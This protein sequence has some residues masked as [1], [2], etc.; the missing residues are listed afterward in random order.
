MDGKSTGTENRGLHSGKTIDGE[1]KIGDQLCQDSLGGLYE[2]TNAEKDDLIIKLFSG[3]I[4][5]TAT[6]E[7]YPL[8]PN[9]LLPVAV[10]APGKL[11]RYAVVE[12]FVKTT[13]RDWM[14]IRLHSTAENLIAT[15]LQLTSA[16]HAIHE[17]GRALGNLCPEIVLI[18]E[19]FMGKLEVYLLDANIQFSARAMTQRLYQPLEQL[20]APKPTVAGDIWSVGAMMYEALYKH[21]PYSGKTKDELIA[22]IDKETLKF[23]TFARVPS[24]FIRIIQK[25]LAKD[26]Q[27]RYASMQELG[28]DL[29]LLQER[30]V[31]KNVSSEA[32]QKAIHDSII[33]AARISVAPSPKEK[34]ARF[35]LAS[36]SAGHLSQTRISEVPP[37]KVASRRS[38]ASASS[39]RTSKAPQKSPSSATRSMLTWE[40]SIIPKTEPQASDK[41]EDATGKKVDVRPKTD[42]QKTS[43]DKPR[44]SKI[45]KRKATIAFAKDPFGTEEPSTALLNDPWQQARNEAIQKKKPEKKTTQASGTAPK[46]E[47]TTAKKEPQTVSAQITETR[48]SLDDKPQ[49]DIPIKSIQKKTQKKT[50]ATAGKQNGLLEK[51]SSPDAKGQPEKDK[52]AIAPEEKKPTQKKSTVL[53][54]QAVAPIDITPKADKAGQKNRERTGT[55]QAKRPTLKKP[56]ASLKDEKPQVDIAAPTQQTAG[57]DTSALETPTEQAKRPRSGRPR[58]QTML[59]MPAIQ[60]PTPDVVSDKMVTTDASGSRPDTGALEIPDSD[61]TDDMEEEKTLPVSPQALTDAMRA[62]AQ[63]L[64]NR[65]DNT[66]NSDISSPASHSNRDALGDKLFDDISMADFRLPVDPTMQPRLPGTFRDEAPVDSHRP[67]PVVSPPA[68]GGE[69]METSAPNIPRPRA[70]IQLKMAAMARRMAQ[71]FALVAIFVGRTGKTA[72]TRVATLWKGKIASGHI[73]KKISVGVT[74]SWHRFN[75]LERKKKI[76]A[77]SVLAMVLLLSAIGIALGI[78]A[79]GDNRSQSDLEKSVAGGSESLSDPKLFDGEQQSGGDV[80]Q[81]TGDSVEKKSTRD[82]KK[83]RRMKKA[84]K[85]RKKAR[86]QSIISK[87]ESHETGTSGASARDEKKRA[88]RKYKRRASLRK[89]EVSGEDISDP[90]YNAGI[91]RGTNA[92]D[93]EAPPKKPETTAKKAAPKKETETQGKTIDNKAP[94]KTKP[95]VKKASKTEKPKAG[96]KSNTGAPKKKSKEKKPKSGDWATNPF[97]G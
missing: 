31:D 78:S 73:R 6:K 96:Q 5:I 10:S 42:T 43:E 85:R 86:R 77:L 20:K 29:L 44:K 58:S 57:I 56:A 24:A 76:I 36:L 2:C 66:A 12:S 54:G 61:W 19:D 65:D 16:I 94:K 81:A 48:G 53:W 14:K 71:I 9:I 4:T 55:I 74:A 51:K 45:P 35:S 50:P 34:S 92:V 69:N 32:A 88:E 62:Q 87:A 79:S 22:Q 37:K 93:E 11:P 72:G 91:R 52:P 39:S 28:G 41:K 83:K 21:K 64:L 84:E 63:W 8:H 33:P 95:V 27:K 60:Y 40:G 25:C 46:K 47:T 23:A 97:G 80:N 13:L 75:S 38:I 82:L 49:N 59:G 68:D 3:G 7:K 67:T 89:S 17:T 30:A 26:V 70:G 18:G 90:K 1:Y 15:M